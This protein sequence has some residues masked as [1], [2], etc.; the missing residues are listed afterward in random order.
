MKELDIIEATFSGHMTPDLVQS[1]YTAIMGHEHKNRA[2]QY[3]LI[4]AYLD[5][6]NQFCIIAINHMIA[7]LHNF[8]QQKQKQNGDL[9]FHDYDTAGHIKSTY[10]L[11]LEHFE[12]YASPH[13]IIGVSPQIIFYQVEQWCPFDQDRFNYFQYLQTTGSEQLF[14]STQKVHKMMTQL[15]SGHLY[16]MTQALHTGIQYDDIA[17]GIH[18]SIQLSEMGTKHVSNK[19]TPKQ[20]HT[21]KVLQFNL[22]IATNLLIPVGLGIGRSCKY[23]KGRVFKIDATPLDHKLFI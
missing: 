10:T 5:E 14:S 16:G 3:P 1:A 15:V 9:I 22:H 8:I 21:F 4:Q 13:N 2:N 6:E 20:F 17:V 18:S 11:R 7:K 19:S 23:N 12:S